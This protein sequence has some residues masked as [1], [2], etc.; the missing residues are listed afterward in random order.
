MYNTE[1]GICTTASSSLTIFPIAAFKRSKVD[2][3]GSKI[4][5]RNMEVVCNRNLK[6]VGRGRKEHGGNKYLCL[7][8]AMFD[9]CFSRWRAELGGNIKQVCV[10]FKRL[11]QL[12]KKGD[13]VKMS[14][15]HFKNAEDLHQNSCNRMQATASMT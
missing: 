11:S 5:S 2:L 6:Y 4:V 10:P 15:I 8:L 12:L 13:V 3:S 1:T 7:M 14:K 9:V